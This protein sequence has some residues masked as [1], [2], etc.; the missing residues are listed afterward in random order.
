M[1]ANRQDNAQLRLRAKWWLQTSWDINQMVGGHFDFGAWSVLK[2][3]NRN[4]SSF[5]QAY[6]L[7][8]D[9]N[10]LRWLQLSYP[11]ILLIPI[12]PHI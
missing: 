6:L 5:Q 2:A 10:K 1:Q 3:D 8:T 12:P 4:I 9:A 11:A 7:T